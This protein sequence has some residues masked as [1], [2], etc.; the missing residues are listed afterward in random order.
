MG[1]FK[2]RSIHLKHGQRLTFT[3]EKKIGDENLVPVQYPRFHQEVKKGERIFLDDGN[4]SGVV[5]QVSG[6][7]VDVE[8]QTGGVLSDHKGINLPDAKLTAD[9]ITAKDKAICNLGFRKAFI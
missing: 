7:R 3:A 5:K 9:L 1:K 4:L 8:I 6:Q 2:E